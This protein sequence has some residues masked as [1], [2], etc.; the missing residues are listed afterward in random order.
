MLKSQILLENK[1]EVKATEHPA[2]FAI[3]MNTVSSVFS[4]R[5]FAY[6]FAVI[7]LLIFGAFG[8]M[9]LVPSEKASPKLTAALTGQS[10]VKKNVVALNSKINDFAQAA[11]TGKTNNV[12]S[13]INA[14]NANAKDLAQSLKNSPTQDAATLKDI[15]SGLKT[16]ADV[17]GTDLTANPDVRDLYQTVV[18]GQIADLQKTTLTDNQKKTLSDAEGLYGQGKYADALEKLLLISQ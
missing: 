11:K 4:Q 13:A 15:A 3:F 18:Q 16:L 1:A 10:S 2:R 9:K 17:S 5:K 12:P 7:L 6:S 14:I 8:L